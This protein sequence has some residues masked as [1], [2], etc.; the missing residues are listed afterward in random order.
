MK[1][2]LL[3]VLLFL[4][5]SALLSYEISFN[6]KFSKSISG[7]LLTTFVNIKVED[8]NEIVINQKIEE[9]NKF[10]KK[11]NKVEKKNGNFTLSP[12]YKYTK[13]TQVFVG[14]IGSLRYKIESKSAKNLNKF[15]NTL[16]TIKE[17]NE[18]KSTK[19]SFSNISWRLSKNLSASSIDELRISAITWIEAYSNSLT[20]TL[21]KD[22]NVKKINID[23]VMQ[24]YGRNYR[25]AESSLGLVSSK[26]VSNV[27]PVNSNQEITINPNFV[28]ECK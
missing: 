28:L 15:I 5:P 20:T 25:M 11:Y 26:K 16:I 27:T 8:K 22:C 4:L 14:Y 13:N 12:K 6:K 18:S 9:F 19:L 10:I 2:S 23:N 24:Q 7:D 21:S 1:K 3:L 17:K